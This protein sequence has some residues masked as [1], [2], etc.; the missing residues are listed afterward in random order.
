MRRPPYWLLVA[1]Y[2]SVAV[3]AVAVLAMVVAVTLDQVGR[4]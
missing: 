3:S 1:L 4:G 2:V